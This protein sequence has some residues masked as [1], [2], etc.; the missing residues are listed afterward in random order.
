MPNLF[1]I[2][3]ANGAGK[4]TLSQFLL[5]NEI[6]HLNVLMGIY[7]L[8]KVFKRFFLHK[9][10]LQNMPEIWLF[11]LLLKSLKN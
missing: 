1:V 10:N 4:S 3:G 9:Q 5:P 6:A 2:T 7:F 8:L 11:K